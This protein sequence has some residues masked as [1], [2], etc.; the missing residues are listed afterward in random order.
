MAKA[1][2]A[3]AWIL[4]GLISL[5]VCVYRV[6]MVDT[7]PVTDFAWYWFRA[8]SIAQGEGYSIDGVATAYWPVGYPAVLAAFLKVFGQSL[9]TAKALNVILTVASASLVALLGRRLF[10][11]AALGFLAG[12]AWALHPSAVAYAGILASEPLYLVCVLVGALGMSYSHENFKKAMLIAIPA[13]CL[14]VYVRPQ[15]VLLPVLFGVALWLDG[16]CSER[17]RDWRIW[18][19]AAGIVLLAI[20]ITQVP[21]SIRNKNQLGAYVFVSTNGGDN[22]MIGHA[23]NSEGGYIHPSTL[24]EEPPETEVDRDRL[25]RSIAMQ[26][27]RRNPMGV[28]KRVPQK[29]DMTFGKATDTQYWMFQMKFNELS[30]PGVG[31]EREALLW[32]RQYAETY[33][34]YLLICSGIGAFLFLIS[35]FWSRLRPVSWIPVMQVAGTVIVVAIFFGNPR[36]AYPAWPFFCLL[37]AYIPFAVFRSIVGNSAGKA[38]KS[39]RRSRRASSRTTP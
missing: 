11:S 30:T 16:W 15:A 8:L 25:A 3:A 10:R 39:G 17:S 13:L 2:Q 5:V 32:Y 26:E 9:A 6:R 21:W 23:T 34:N 24:M 12:T 18:A 14:A 27:I 35:L 22:L 37:T 20:V 4:P 31:D 1:L 38:R 36:F 29:V 28:F 33:R 19:K 7:Q